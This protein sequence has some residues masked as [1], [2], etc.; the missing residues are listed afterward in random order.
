MLPVINQGMVQNVQLIDNTTGTVLGAGAIIGA[1]KDAGPFWSTFLG[2]TGSAAVF[3]NISG[4]INAASDSPV[5]GN[6]IV[7][8]GFVVSTD[9]AMRVDIQEETTGKILFTLFLAANSS[10]H[11]F[12]R[13]KVKLSSSNKRVMI[14]P[15]NV[16]NIA[17]STS[18][19][20]E[21]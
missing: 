19:Y 2:V 17:I 15:Y 16:G 6:T 9:T 21:P 10:L 4:T 18:Y 20:S 1:T 14:K 3:T 12:P 5:S 8:L 7:L 11:V 13:G